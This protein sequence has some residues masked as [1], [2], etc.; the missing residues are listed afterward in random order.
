MNL[1]KKLKLILAVVVLAS[2]AS[3][4]Q[5]MQPKQS[6][7][8]LVNITD[9]GSVRMRLA[10]EDDVDQLLR[11]FEVIEKDQN[12]SKKLVVLPKQIR[13]Q[14]LQEAIHLRRIFVVTDDI[15]GAADKDCFIIGFTKIYALGDPSERKEVLE[16][17][18]R[19][20]GSLVDK[21]LIFSDDSTIVYFG[22][23]Y[24]EPGSR[25][26]GIGLALVTYALKSLVSTLMVGQVNMVYGKA[27]GGEQATL[28]KRAFAN[29]LTGFDC[30]PEDFARRFTTFVYPA[31]MPVLAMNKGEVVDIREGQP[32]NDFGIVLSGRLSAD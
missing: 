29:L 10:V 21:P 31:R 32:L 8:D 1:L 20:S 30:R 9:F 12:D 2:T 3:S 27:R 16:R 18:I 17:E 4:L 24:T 11:H 6:E 22:S 19:C 15:E 25:N 5:A 23:E 13:K 7:T 14:A 26:K 28:P